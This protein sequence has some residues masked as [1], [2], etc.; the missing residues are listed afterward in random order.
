MDGQEQEK[1]LT[2]I[3]DLQG[4]Q[5]EDVQIETAPTR[6][7]PGRKIM[8]VRLRNE[9]AT[10]RCPKCGKE[11][12]HFLF[13]EYEPRRF[14]DS[15]MGEWETHVEIIPVRLSCCGGSL[16]ET[17]P[18]EAPG[19][20]R[21][22]RRFFERVA[23]LCTRM[24]VEA[25]ADM[26][27]LSWDTVAK[28]DRLATRMA[29]G[30]VSPS[31]DG[32]RWMGADEVSRTGG[33]VF[34]T[35][36]TDLISGRV[37]WVGD[38]KG[39]RALEEFFKILGGKRC[40]KIQG[41]VSDLAPGYLVAIADAIPHAKHVL[42]RFHIVQWANEALNTI[43]RRI[44]GGVPK[45][46][47]G[48]VLKLK[49]WLLLSAREHLKAQD[50]RLLDQLGKLNMPL[51][52]AYLLKEELRAIL[53]HPWKYEGALLRNLKAWAHAVQKAG[54]REL[55]KVATRLLTHFD[56]LAAGFNCGVR[57]GFVEATNGKIALIRRQSRGI[58]DQEYFRFKIYQRCS[59]P[60]NPWAGIVL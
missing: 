52:L 5:I 1:L 46:D 10:H 44:F 13:K 23:A 51:Y 35:I 21:M 22:T 9:R 20:H 19:G 30:G 45:Q 58:R 53:H 54:H 28:I 17:F 11:H 7:S 24:T 33:R 14:R 27:G 12:R 18:W 47:L 37:V 42:D 50:R 40:K 25:A 56:K 38:G 32:L 31:L 43:R 3:W 26:L 49:K 57:L 60:N 2:A 55:I 8:V 15:S 34:F 59:L 6:R 29:L 41:V 48:R 16:V 4:C 39:K 36:V